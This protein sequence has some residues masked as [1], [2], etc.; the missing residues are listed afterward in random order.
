MSRSFPGSFL[1]TV[2]RRDCHLSRFAFSITLFRL[3]SFIR[4][5]KARDVT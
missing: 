3:S 2:N 5:F 4:R 1:G